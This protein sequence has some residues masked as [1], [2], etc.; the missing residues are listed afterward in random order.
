M[1]N[2]LWW[3]LLGLGLL[4]VLP[5]LALAQGPVTENDV[6]R[7]ARQL[8]CP[9]CPNTP[10]DVCETQA[11]QDWRALIRQ[12]L[13]AGETDRQIIAYFVSQYGER[14][15]T[16][17]PARGFNLL[18]WL[19][20]ILGILAGVAFLALLFREWLRRRGPAPLQAAI[21]SPNPLADL[22]QDYVARLER[23][24]EKLKE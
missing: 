22:P 21:G 19:V 7:V 5:G 2:R 20:P 16:A 10:L 23:E 6:M 15:L 4:A 9:I 12:K 3:L 8:Y 14:V 1:M 18:G 13:E 17:P 24:L 11:C